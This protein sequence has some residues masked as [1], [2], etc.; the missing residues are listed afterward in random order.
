MK[1]KLCLLLALVLSVS[2]LAMG[3]GGDDNNG[4]GASSEDTSLTDIQ[5]KGT[6]VL[7][8]DDEFPPMGFVNEAG[9]LTGFD[10]ELAG[11][12]AEK[13]GVT[14]EATPIDWST[15][16]AQLKGGSIDVIWNG[17]TITQVRDKKVEFTKPYLNNAV[18]IAVKADSDI[19]TIADLSGKVIASQTDSSGLTAINGNE[20]LLNSVKEVREFNNFTEAMLDLKSVRVDAVA[21]DK[22]VANYM[23]RQTPGEY[24]LLDETLGDEL[25]GIGCRKGAVALREAIDKALDEL[26]EDGSI[27]ILSNKYFG[28]NVVIRDIDK[29]APDEITVVE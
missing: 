11:L 29:L 14:L 8:C 10:I 24:R 2:V 18:V 6:L 19:Q 13:M 4:G 12:V 20:E 22:V 9:D 21:V 27:E 25:Y 23:M 16:E 28:T 17:Y 3:C 1:K 26:N 15:K 5:A 7:G